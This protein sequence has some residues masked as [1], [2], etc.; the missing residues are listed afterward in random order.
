MTLGLS[1]LTAIYSPTFLAG[2]MLG[3]LGM[4]LI[5][6]A[7]AHHND[8]RHPLPGGYKHSVGGLDRM[9]VAGAITAFTMGYVLLQ[10][11]RTHDYS[12]RIDRDAHHCQVEFNKAIEAQVNITKENDGIALEQRNLNI[13][14]IDATGQWVS[15][16]YSPPASVPDSQRTVWEQ[17]VTRAYVSRAHEIR[18]R[19]AVLIRRQDQLVKDRE[20][21]PVPPLTCG[22]DAR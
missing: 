16:L 5:I 22:A 12:T 9:W 6:R 14:L 11:E 7:Q 10:A 13:S 17:G 2:G 15:D 19:I 4:R 21:H 1:L 20:A 8:R 18:D 3:C